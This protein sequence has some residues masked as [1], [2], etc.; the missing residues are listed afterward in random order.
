MEINVWSEEMKSRRYA[1]V[2]KKRCVACGACM[3]ECPRRAIMIWKGCYAAID[4]E[5]CVGCGKC[6]DVCPAGSIEILMREEKGHE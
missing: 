4:P 5:L 1:A 2:D 6:K 3:Q